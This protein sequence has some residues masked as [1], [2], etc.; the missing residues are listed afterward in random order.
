MIGL[1]IVGSLTPALSGSFFLF[2]TLA[3][4][5]LLTRFGFVAGHGVPHGGDAALR[6][7]RDVRHEGLVRRRGAA[8][9]RRARGAH[10][11]GRADGARSG[12]SPRGRNDGEWRRVESADQ[13]DS[14]NETDDS[15]G[16]DR[17]GWRSDR[18]RRGRRTRRPRRP[19]PS[20]GRP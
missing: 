15:R 1:Q 16:G 20:R 3:F 17:G 8:L 11:L 12:A 4:L 19:R 10:G 7:S 14:K 13:E 5:V 18:R 6:L 9:P 2:T